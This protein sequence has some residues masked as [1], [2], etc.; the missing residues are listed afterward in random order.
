MPQNWRFA[1]PKCNHPHLTCINP[2]ELIRKYECSDCGEIMMCACEEQI[3]KKFLPH[4]L[5]FAT[6]LDSQQRVNVSAGFV[7]SICDECRGLPATPYPKAST[8]GQT[9]KIKRYYWRELVFREY[10]LFEKL[11]GNPANYLYERGENESD[12]LKLAK[13]QALLDIK[14]LH[15]TTPKYNYEEESNESF[16][17][18]LGIKLRV[19]DG[20][21]VKGDGRKAKIS[22]NNKL[23]TVEKF[24][25]VIYQRQG[26]D[27]IS[28]ESVPFHVLFAVF[29][30]IIIQDF[31]DPEV[32]VIGFGERSAYEKDCSKN[33]IWTTLPS[34]F[35]TSGY[36]LKR[37]EKIAAHF[38]YIQGYSEDILWLFDYWLPYSEGLR[39]YLWAHKD[40]HI[41]KARKIIEILG[42]ETILKIVQYLIDDYWRRYLG[43]P[44]LLVFKE[45]HFLFVEVKL[46]KDKLS[47]EQ[48]LWIENNINQL[49]LPFEILK[50]NRVMTQQT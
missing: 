14:A 45:G 23:L 25:A 6:R 27:V 30:W 21:Y 48:R 3:A 40:E 37:K 42:A 12:I 4:Q 28:L 2:Y 24:A 29:T 26:Y 17:K 13:K 20:Q 11:G 44:D 9:S 36:A 31:T 8:I 19:I 43:W 41:Q 22:Y 49:H 7:A 1:L 10:E 32:Q 33:L 5:S 15:A 34:D 38:D 39:Q 47:D 18:R 50:I 16:I 35:G 46:S